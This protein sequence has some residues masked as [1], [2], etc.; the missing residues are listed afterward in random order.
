MGKRA[1]SGRARYDKVATGFDQSAMAEAEKLFERALDLH[2][3]GQLAAALDLYQQVLQR[4]PGHLDALQ[5]LGALELQNGHLESAEMFLRRAVAMAPETPALQC[6][7]GLAL[8]RLGRMREALACFDRALEVKPDM[9]EAHLNRGNLLRDLGRFADAQTALRMALGIR[10]DMPEAQLSLGMLLKDM[11][12][13]AE[14]VSCFFHSLRSNPRQPDTLLQAAITLLELSRP[15]EAMQCVDQCLRLQ[16]GHAE[17]LYYRGNALLALRR[18]EEAAACY[19]SSIQIRP[20][21]AETHYNLANLLLDLGRHDLAFQSF[22]RAIALRPDYAEAH[23]NLGCGLAEVGRHGEAVFPLREA[24]RLNPGHRFAGGKLCFSLL[25]CCDWT[26]YRDTVSTIAENV[27]SGFSTD[28]PFSFLAVSGDA[29]LQKLCAQKYTHDRY[30]PLG[31]VTWQ[32][33]PYAHE[34]IRIAY[35]SADFREHPV[36]YLMAGVF[37]AHDKRHFETIGVS[38]RAKDGSALGE[39]V[40]AAFDRFI[41]ASSMTDAGVAALI[42][43][44]EVDIAVDLTGHTQDNRTGIFARR[45]APVQVNYLGFPGTMGAEYMDYILADEFV[46]PEGA[47]S[48]YSEHVVRLPDCFQANDDRR[49][50]AEHRPA[51]REVGLPEKD[52]VFCAFNNLYKINPPIFDVWMRILRAVP[53]SVLWLAA[54]AECARTNL[55]REAESRG[56]DGQRLVFVSRVPYAEHLARMGLADLFLDTLPFNAGTTASDALWAGL[57]ILTRAGEAFASRMAGSMLRAIGLPELITHELR[58]Y[59]ELAI[60]LA[61]SPDR[62]ASIRARLREHRARKPLFDTLRFTRHLEAAYEIMREKAQLGC[63]PS[64]FSV[65][66]VNVRVA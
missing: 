6:N 44:L 39:R 27:R 60:E 38:L 13:P 31:P 37:E 24:A 32:G 2:R 18:K 52:F 23:Y 49:P 36:S 53:D 15:E 8:Q 56:V 33:N 9:V 7:H 57:P 16:P 40:A 62:L 3:R 61:S 12:Q 45:P 59:E 64:D 22:R 48:H 29:H 46:I 65:P 1:K 41:D 28:A 43:E 34:K 50:I 26:S 54:D 58:D 11:N 66:P 5:L 30:P 63:S 55:I 17:A 19:L 10:P 47:Q 42:R 20:D 51:R 14:A 25:F 21:I 35:V 4:Q